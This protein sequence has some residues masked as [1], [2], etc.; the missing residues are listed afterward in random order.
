MNCS[1]LEAAIT[2][3]NEKDRVVVHTRS[4]LVDKDQ[5]D[6][7]QGA[8]YCNAVYVFTPQRT[9]LSFHCD[10]GRYDGKLR[11]VLPVISASG[12]AVRFM[13]ERTVSVRKGTAAVKLSADKPLSRLPSTGDR[14]FN[15]VPGLEAIPLAILQN[16]AVIDITVTA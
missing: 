1:D 7:A 15:F 12:E 4:R 5:H 3:E 8:V 6:P 16:E 13:D 10:K 11:I 14:L 2:V 9:T